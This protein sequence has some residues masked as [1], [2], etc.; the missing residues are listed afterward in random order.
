MTNCPL[1]PLSPSL[2]LSLRS[3]LSLSSPLS[4]SLPL[5]LPAVSSYGFTVLPCRVLQYSKVLRVPVLTRA[6]G[7]TRLPPAML[8]ADSPFD[9]PPLSRSMRS[10]PATPVEEEEEEEER[11]WLRRQ[12]EET[13]AVR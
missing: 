4:P 8:I 5:I 1:S 9:T 3:L 12:L 6:Y 7:A 13:G 10:I 11:E 2:P